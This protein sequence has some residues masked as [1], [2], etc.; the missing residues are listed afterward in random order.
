MTK[1]TTNPDGTVAV[2]TV[3]GDMGAG[4]AAAPWATREWV[5]ARAEAAMTGRMLIE[6]RRRM[7]AA[8]AGL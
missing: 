7:R 1:T 6:A 5:A 2:E 8:L 3:A 4:L